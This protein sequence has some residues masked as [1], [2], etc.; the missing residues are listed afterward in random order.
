[1]ADPSIF[2]EG[3]KTDPYWWDLAPPDDEGDAP[4]PERADVVIVGSGYTGLSAALELARGG[5][6][7]VV[8]EAFRFGEGASTRSGGMVSGGVNVGKGGDIEKLYGA[9]RV[10]AMIEEA[11]ESYSH[12]EQIIERENIDCQYRRSGRFV[13][14]HTPSAYA[15]MA[16]RVETLNAQASA[17]HPWF[18][19]LASA[20]NWDRTSITAA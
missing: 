11:A 15:A 20:S 14:A 19:N 9:D 6:D 12:F 13:G 8:L 7:V 2:A 5:V 3:F 10:G 4:P 16:A 17:G 18:R 1:M